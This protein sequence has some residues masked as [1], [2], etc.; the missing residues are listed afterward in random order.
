LV[1][2]RDRITGR[3]GRGTQPPAVDSALSTDT[4]RL[5]R[6]YRLVDRRV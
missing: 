5:G 6:F 2:Q 1:I 3:P 4:G